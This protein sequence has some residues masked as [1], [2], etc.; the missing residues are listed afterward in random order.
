MEKG[1]RKDESIVES[2]NWLESDVEKQINLKKKKLLN[3]AQVDP[4]FKEV[5]PTKNPS[6]QSTG[7]LHKE[8]MCCWP[9]FRA[10]LPS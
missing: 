4:S 8:V 10:T 1:G 7:G 5:G 2:E 6:S 9:N 3:S